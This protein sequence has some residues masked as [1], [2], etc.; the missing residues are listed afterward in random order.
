MPKSMSL[1]IVSCFAAC[2][3]GLQTASAQ[4]PVRSPAGSD[5]AGKLEALTNEVLIHALLRKMDATQ[6][7]LKR[8]LECAWGARTASEAYKKEMERL[9]PLFEE[10]CRGLHKEDEGNKGLSEEVMHRA[11][12]LEHDVK[13]AFKAFSDKVNRWE[14]RALESLTAAQKA[15]VEDL[16]SEGGVRK[17]LRLLDPA[18]PGET[19]KSEKPSL[20]A[21]RVTLEAARNLTAE[22]WKEQSA[23][24]VENLVKGWETSRAPLPAE[25]RERFREHL[26][27][28][29][30]EVRAM[31]RKTFDES[32]PGIARSMRPPDR[33]EELRAEL[34]EI[35]KAKYGAIGD[36]GRFLLNDRLIPV[37]EGK[38]G[39]K[40]GASA[41]ADPGRAGDGSGKK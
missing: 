33:I 19:P 5:M 15:M 14:D 24:F 22:Q 34:K 8:F 7:Q 36:V 40:P 21:V 16:R 20:K 38:L 23:G 32:L 10:A 4:D 12:R 39:M 30:D 18:K 35:T 13:T 29:L 6:D 1:A 31:D 2:I 3:A 41:P 27:D 37:L 17:L 9:N 25:D 28:L 26:S 11:A